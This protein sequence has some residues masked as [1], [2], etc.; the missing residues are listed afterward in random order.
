V[1][2]PT[3]KGKRAFA[4]GQRMRDRKPRGKK[5]KAV[6]TKLANLHYVM[7]RNGPG[8]GTQTIF[9]KL[10]KKREEDLWLLGKNVGGKIGAPLGQSKKNIKP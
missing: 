3:P 9:R 4:C 7:S 1:M 5:R 2:D 6:C 8:K 10:M